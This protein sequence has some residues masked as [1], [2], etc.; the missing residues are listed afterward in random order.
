[1]SEIFGPGLAHPSEAEFDN[2]FWNVG[3]KQQDTGSNTYGVGGVFVQVRWVGDMVDLRGKL[4]QCCADLE[5]TE[6]DNLGTVVGG[7]FLVD[8]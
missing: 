4:A 6:I 2:L 5:V 3:Q 7:T 1:M 8:A